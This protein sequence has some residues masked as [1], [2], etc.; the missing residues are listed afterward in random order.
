[1]DGVH[2]L[3]FVGLALGSYFDMRTREIP[4]LLNFLLLGFGVVYALFSGIQ[5]VSWT[6]VISA[7]LGYAAG[8]AIGNGFF[9][10]GQWGGGDTKT[11]IAMGVIIGLGISEFSRGVPALFVFLVNSLVVGAILGLFWLMYR[12][13]RNFA[14]FKKEFS[15]LRFN[16]K[17]IRIRK[18]ILVVGII[19]FGII[20]FLVSDSLMKMS[21]LA[22]LVLLILSFYLFMIIR[23]AEN[24]V[25][26]VEYPVSKLTE[27]DWIVSVPGNKVDFNKT[28]ASL[29][30]IEKLKKMR[31]KSVL[32]KEGVPFLPAFLI[33]YIVLLVFGNWMNLFTIF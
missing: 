24:S 8:W 19:S 4:D 12:V 23:A 13:V 16:P 6:P 15:R 32:V 9:Y 14:K 22:V 33:G 26:F 25:M 28:G 27:G 1:M 10:L 21:M 31:I 18:I 30:D 11:F 5:S 17:N 29:E 7:A 2:V 20:M 3:V